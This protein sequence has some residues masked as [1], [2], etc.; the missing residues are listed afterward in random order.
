[1]FNSLHQKCFANHCNRWCNSILTILKWFRKKSNFE[2]RQAA[3]T[4]K[5]REKKNLSSQNIEQK[6]AQKKSISEEKR[7]HRKTEKKMKTWPFCFQP[8]NLK[9]WSIW[10]AKWS[11][12]PDDALKFIFFCLILTN[13]LETLYSSSFFKFTT[14]QTTTPW[15]RSTTTSSL[16]PNGIQM[17]HDDLTEKLNLDPTSNVKITIFEANDDPRSNP[18]TKTSRL[19]QISVVEETQNLA[20]GVI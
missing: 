6:K 20:R 11:G 2:Q 10:I 16:D 4:E 18:T 14:G 12:F 9:S 19:V 17:L 1:M 3:Y 13:A 15:H 7:K 8:V 5:E